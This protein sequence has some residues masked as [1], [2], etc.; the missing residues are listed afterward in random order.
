MRALKASDWFNR[1]GFPLSIV[2]RNP[3]EK[4]TLHTHE[5][6]E[7]VIILGGRALHVIGNESWPVV[8]G[9]VFVVGG[10]EAHDYREMKDLRLIN[11]LFSP[12]RLLIDPL[13]LPALPG[14]QV[15]FS[16]G[17]RNS[18]RTLRLAPG[19]L[20]VGLSY[21]ETLSH[22]LDTRNPGFEFM[23][24]ARFMQ[25][26][27]FLSRVNSQSRKRPDPNAMSCVGKAISH[28]EAHFA[29][30]IKLDELARLTHMSKRHFFRAFQAATGSTPIAYLVNL[31]LTHA[32]EMLRRYDETVTSVAYKVGFNDSNYFARR[33]RAMFGV[34]P[35]EYRKWH[36]HLFG[37]PGDA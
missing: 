13:D 25:L 36:E 12:E 9:D 16:R 33:F 21:V 30:P 7:I 17:E 14:Y 5:F 4:F 18:L 37:S 35:S 15:L 8:A 3:H 2:W 27:C 26:V 11:I 10:S 1:D 34:T 32:A 29:Q 23:S 19:E 22:E 20:G 24:R 31:R 28:L 6:S